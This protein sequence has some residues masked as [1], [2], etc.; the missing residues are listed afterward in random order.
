MLGSKSILWAGRR[1]G[2]CWAAWLG[3]VKRPDGVCRFR[4][5]LYYRTFVLLLSKGFSLLAVLVLLMTEAD[6]A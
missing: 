1:V 4:T 5:C 6:G 2:G 3:L